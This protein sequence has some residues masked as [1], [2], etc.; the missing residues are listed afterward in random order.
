MVMATLCNRDG[1][2]PPSDD[3]TCIFANG[4]W[5]YEDPPVEPLSEEPEIDPREN[6]VVSSFQAKAALL[7]AGLLDEVESFFSSNDATAVQKL[8]WKETTNF[9]RLSQLVISTGY[10][11]GLSDA[12]LDELFINAGQITI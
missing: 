9:Y 11:L 12:Q 4:T 7:A 8:A 5:I 2:S 1:P 10:L 3:M 6:M